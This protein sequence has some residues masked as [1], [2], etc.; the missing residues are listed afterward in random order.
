[1]SRE[2]NLYF[3]FHSDIF[4][5]KSIFTMVIIKSERSDLYYLKKPASLCEIHLTLCGA[6]HILFLKEEI[7]GS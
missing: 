4:L 6:R 7:T 1:M 5:L 3:F 2:E